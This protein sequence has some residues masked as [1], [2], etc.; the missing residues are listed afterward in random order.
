MKSKEQVW[1]ETELGII[2]AVDHA[3]EE[4]EGWADRA[5]DLLC[6]YARI[7]KQPFCSDELRMW[8]TERGLPE[9]PHRRAWGGV[10]LKASR[11][12]VIMAAGIKN[13]HYPDSDQSHTTNMKFWE[14]FK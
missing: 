8:A 11:R 12:D 14:E 10:F 4:Y 1:L 2:Q 6:R 5:F 7:R 13:Y 9:P 3:D